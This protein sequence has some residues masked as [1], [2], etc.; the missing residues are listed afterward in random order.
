MYDVNVVTILKLRE[1][2]SLSIN[3]SKLASPL[4]VKNIS[5]YRITTLSVVHTSPI[6]D[7]GSQELAWHIMF[8]KG[9]NI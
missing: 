3:K 4:V 2:K 6:L 5:I 8:A 9:D 1:T 7:Q